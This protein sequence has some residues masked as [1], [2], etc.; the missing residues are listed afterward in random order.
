MPILTVVQDRSV[1]LRG[2]QSVM[3]QR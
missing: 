2:I 3:A 1:W